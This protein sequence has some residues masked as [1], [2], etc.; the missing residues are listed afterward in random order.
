MPK[1]DVLYCTHVRRSVALMALQLNPPRRRAFALLGYSLGPFANPHSPPIAPVDT[2][3]RFCPRKTVRGPVTRDYPP[4]HALGGSTA[5]AT[6]AGSA[7]A[8]RSVERRLPH[9]KKILSNLCS[10]SAAVT[11]RTHG[12]EPQGTMNYRCETELPCE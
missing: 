8:R 7:A 1:Y 3:V 9:V 11:C 10:S 12:G 6:V 5:I 2:A 4:Q